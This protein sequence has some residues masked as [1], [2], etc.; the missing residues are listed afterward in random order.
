MRRPRHNLDYPHRRR[1]MDHDLYDWSIIGERPPLRWPDGSPLAV[2]PVIVVEWFPLTSRNTPFRPPS[3]QYVG[4]RPYPD[5]RAYTHLDYGNRVGVYRLLR[6]LERV[7]VRAS[8]AINAA[9]AERYP[10]ILR[11]IGQGGHEVIAHGL[12]MEHVHHGGMKRAQERSWIREALSTLRDASGQPVTGW[13]SPDVSQSM[14]TLDLLAGEGVDYVCDWVN[15]DLPYLLRTKSGP[16]HAMPFAYELSD[17]LVL[18]DLRHSESQFLQ[19]IHDTYDVLHREGMARGGRI[20]AMTFHAW[21]MG[22]PH[23][24]GYFEEMLAWLTSAAGTWNA[25]GA[26]ILAASKGQKNGS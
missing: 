22:H 3:D 5:Y 19:Q 25:T 17:R 9:A 21:I 14:N 10:E 7:G 13:L 16:L 24:I 12:D 2:W 11:A 8:V 23:R 6:A 1:G 26:E 15:D 18:L 4:V 20:M